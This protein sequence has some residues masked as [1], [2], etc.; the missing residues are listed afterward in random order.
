MDFCRRKV[1]LLRENV[2]KLGEARALRAPRRRAARV[3]TAARSH[4]ADCVASLAQI[5]AVKNRQMRQVQT[6]L[7]AT[8]ARRG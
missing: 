3:L 5:I 8:Q 4:R 6:Q 1:N 2:D 7:A